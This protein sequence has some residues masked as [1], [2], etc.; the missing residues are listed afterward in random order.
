MKL[1]KAAA[2]VLTGVMALGMASVTGIFADEAVSGPI[3]LSVS[4]LNNPF[5]VTLSEGA[6]EKEDRC[7]DCKPGGFRCGR[8]GCRRCH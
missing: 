8:S 5:F 4:T 1:K 7:A 3:G 6:E 2:L